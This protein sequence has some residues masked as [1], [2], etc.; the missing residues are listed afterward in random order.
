MEQDE[1]SL[2]HAR[3]PRIRIMTPTATDKKKG[4]KNGVFVTELKK[5]KCNLS[6]NKN[7]GRQKLNVLLSNQIDM[8]QS[9]APSK[10]N[11]YKLNHLVLFLP[12]H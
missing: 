4:V 5:S 12:K 9:C 3:R 1:T 11:L 8:N 7:C 10:L 6:S 2:D